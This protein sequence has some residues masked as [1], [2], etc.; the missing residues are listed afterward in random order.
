M[1]RIQSI[2]VNAGYI[3]IVQAVIEQA[4]SY[5]HTSFVCVCVC[6]CVNSSLFIVCC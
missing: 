6:V 3:Y 4:A 2:D 5:K 1:T